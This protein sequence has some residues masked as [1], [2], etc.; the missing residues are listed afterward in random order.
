M[1]R[2][3]QQAA[4]LVLMTAYP[5]C[6]D[7]DGNGSPT[8]PTPPSGGG[9]SGATITISS[10]SVN[11]AAVTITVGQVVTFVNNDSR[12]HDISSDP[13]PQHTDCPPIESLGVIGPGQTRETGVFSSARTC[14]FHD[15]NEPE[16]SRLQ[17]TIT[18]R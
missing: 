15:H 10:N 16:N 4:I 11:P 3:I 13:H 5:A 2:R 9:P 1:R 14:G 12:A 17:G 18:I 6:G 8:V 7:G